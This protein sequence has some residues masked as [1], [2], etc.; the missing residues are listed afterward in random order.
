MK[1][2]SKLL[3]LL[4][5]LPI[6]VVSDFHTCIVFVTEGDSVTLNYAEALGI[7]DES[8]TWRIDKLMAGHNGHFWNRSNC[9]DVQCKD[10]NKRLRDRLKVHQNG[11]LTIT[12][13]TIT[14]SGGYWLKVEHPRFGDDVRFY[15][16]VVRG[17]F[18]FDTDGVSVLEG[19]SVTL[20]TG[21]Q[22]KQEQVL[23]WYFNN[24]VIAVIFG[25]LS[26]ICTNERFRDRLR[27]HNQTGSL[28]IRDIRTTDS[29]LYDLLINSYRGSRSRRRTKVFPVAVHVKDPAE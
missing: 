11:S 19:D 26:K 4:M 13:A 16:V 7:E 14:D 15:S 10:R 17:F 9:K 29:G 28:T 24:T 20:H 6:Y 25:D 21:H 27:L 5:Y 18:S 8:F 1:F 23:S 22:M 12:N 3:S 2:V